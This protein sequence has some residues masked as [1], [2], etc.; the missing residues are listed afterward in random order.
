MK[1]ILKNTAQIFRA[2]WGPTM[3][4]SARILALPAAI[5]WVVAQW[6]L[7]TYRKPL[8]GVLALVPVRK[9]EMAYSSARLA[10]ASQVASRIIDPVV[11]PTI[12]IS[13]EAVAGIRGV[14]PGLADYADSI[15]PPAAPLSMVLAPRPRRQ[16]RG[17]KRPQGSA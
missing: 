4:T 7:F 3:K 16:R 1:T 2:D 11:S 13:D 8:A 12:E 9:P 10:M 15:N 14:V 5:V 17:S 6:L